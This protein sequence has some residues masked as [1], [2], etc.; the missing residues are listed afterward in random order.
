MEKDFDKILIQPQEISARVAEVA[1]Q[2]DKDYEGKSPIVIPIFS[3]IWNKNIPAIPI[4]IYEPKSSFAVL[5]TLIAFVI[6]TTY[7][8][9]IAAENI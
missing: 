1:K 6:I 8:I 3:I 2:I 7:R 5:A 4:A 9:T